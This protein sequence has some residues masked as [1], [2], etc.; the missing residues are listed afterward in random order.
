MIFIDWALYTIS[1]FFCFLTFQSSLQHDLQKFYRSLIS[2]CAEESQV[3]KYKFQDLR[4]LH[5]TFDQFC[6][7]N[8]KTCVFVCLKVNC[9]F[10]LNSNWGVL[11]CQ[12]NVWGKSPKKTSTI[13]YYYYLILIL[14]WGKNLNGLACSQ[15]F[16][17]KSFVNYWNGKTFFSK[18]QIR[19]CKLSIIIGSIKEG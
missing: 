13:M 5:F 18:L 1:E 6:K 11:S 9:N 8:S 3:K 17:R 16:N 2:L 15:Q 4:N 12:K 19:S 7:I 14:Q 10:T